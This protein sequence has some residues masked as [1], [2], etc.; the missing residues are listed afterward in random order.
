LGSFVFYSLVRSSAVFIFLLLQYDEMLYLTDSTRQEPLDV[1]T[2]VATNCML[3]LLYCNLYLSDKLWLFFR[4]HTI[5]PTVNIEATTYV[6]SNLRLCWN[7]LFI[8]VMTLCIEIF[9][10]HKISVR[11]AENYNLIYFVWMLF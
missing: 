4:E 2:N 1:G 11:S 10:M 8:F 5:G 6:M 7:V 3:F 9:N